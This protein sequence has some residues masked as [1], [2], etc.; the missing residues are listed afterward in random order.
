MS[1]FDTMIASIMSTTL[2]MLSYHD[3]EYHVHLARD[4]AF[5]AYIACAWHYSVHVHTEGNPHA[6]A[7]GNGPGA[8]DIQ[9]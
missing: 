5:D 9:T 8:L 3:R 2:E 7:V 6:N 1:M 4:A